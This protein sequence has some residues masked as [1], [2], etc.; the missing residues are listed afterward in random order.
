MEHGDTSAAGIKEG[1]VYILHTNE[2]L[3]RLLTLFHECCIQSYGFDGLKREF[4]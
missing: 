1:I 3:Y 4:H 2:A